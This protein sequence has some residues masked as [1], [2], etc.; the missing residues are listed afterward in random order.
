MVAQLGSKRT[1]FGV[2]RG[3]QLFDFERPVWLTLLENETRTCM[4]R[5]WQ[6]CEDPCRSVYG[7]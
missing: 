4:G 1:V 3:D 5:R 7:L 2:V 6:V